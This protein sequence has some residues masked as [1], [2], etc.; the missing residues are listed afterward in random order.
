MTRVLDVVTGNMERPYGRERLSV[1]IDV[2]SNRYLAIIEFVIFHNWW[3][4]QPVL[5]TRRFAVAFF[6]TI[7]PFIFFLP[8]RP[9]LSPLY[10]RSLILK[11]SNRFDIWW[12][13]KKQ[14][15]FA[16]TQGELRNSSVTGLGELECLGRLRLGFGEINS[17][18]VPH[19]SNW[20]S[21]CTN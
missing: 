12:K 10:L 4:I 3:T 8:R 19:S 1:D 11:P 2:F 21:W 15:W 6:F 13:K 14:S 20:L 18:D 17:T 16:V 5:P 7:F 9:S